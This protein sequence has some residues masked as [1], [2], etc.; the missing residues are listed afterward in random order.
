MALI[1]R[2]AHLAP[3]RSRLLV[4]TGCLLVA[5]ACY[6]GY[7]IVSFLHASDV[8]SAALV[9]QFI[10]RRPN[11]AVVLR[12]SENRPAEHTCRTNTSSSARTGEAVLL[13]EIPALHEVAPVLSGTSDAVLA[14]AV[15]HLD[16]SSWPGPGGDV[17]LEAHDVTFFRSLAYLRKGDA[18]DAIGRCAVYSYEV[19]TTDVVDQGAPVEAGTGAHLVLVTCWPTDALFYTTKRYVVVASLRSTR[20]ARSHPPVNVRLPNVK[21]ALPPAIVAMDLNATKAQI[22]L[23]TLTTSARFNADWL[24]SD[25]P[26]Q[27]SDAATHLLEATVVA[28]RARDFRWWAQIAPTLPF[29]EIAP[30]GSTIVWTSPVEVAIEGARRSATGAVLRAHLDI[31]GRPMTLKMVTRVRHGVMTIVRLNLG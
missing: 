6:L 25:R 29:Q 9:R 1:K 7:Q 14:E 13:L 10:V 26:F 5:G 3:C 16:G 17:V 24:D 28:A 8:R 15:G 19:S 2:G 18:I 4:A 12:S 31:R 20:R 21:P 30:L 27:S 22:P 23:G 11:S